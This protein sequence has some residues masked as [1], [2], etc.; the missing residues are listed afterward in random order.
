LMA[1]DWRS[2]NELD[3][4]SVVTDPCKERERRDAAAE[5]WSVDMLT[6]T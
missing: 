1:A 5:Q 4:Q 2:V 6:R 3:A